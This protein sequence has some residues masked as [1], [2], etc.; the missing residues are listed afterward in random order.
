M[1]NIQKRRTRMQKRILSMFLVLSLICC[2]FLL[3]VTGDAKLVKAASTTIT[4]MEY[5]S[6]A[7]GPVISRS[8][9]DSASFGFVCRSLTAVL[10]PGKMWQE[11]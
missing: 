3:P 11:T 10:L 6:P 1:R 9:V 7:D 4:S 2:S 8:G 5:F